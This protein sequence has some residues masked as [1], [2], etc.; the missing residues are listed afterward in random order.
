MHAPLVA[1]NQHDISPHDTRKG[2]SLVEMAVVLAIIGAITGGA[3][4]LGNAHDKSEKA[5]TTKYSSS[6]LSGQYQAAIAGASAMTL[7]TD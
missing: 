3:L 2:Y 5:R 7:A 1:D 6:R 4:V